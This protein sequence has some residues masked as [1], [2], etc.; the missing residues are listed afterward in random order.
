MKQLR[1]H[2]KPSKKRGP[3]IK[4]GEVVLIEEDNVKRLNW[5]IAVIKS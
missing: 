5:P 2:H 3:E 1:E 4:V